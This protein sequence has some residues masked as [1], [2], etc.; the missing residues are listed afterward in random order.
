MNIEKTLVKAFYIAFYPILLLA[1]GFEI[2]YGIYYHNNN[3]L[4]K[5]IQHKYLG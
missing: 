3:Q 1:T 5:V 2:G 4:K